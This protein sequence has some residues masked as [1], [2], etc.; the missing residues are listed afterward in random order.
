M[1]GIHLADNQPLFVNLCDFSDILV[2]FPILQT[3]VVILSPYIWFC[4][5]TIYTLFVS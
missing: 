1:E 2:I 4:M 5:Y 3:I